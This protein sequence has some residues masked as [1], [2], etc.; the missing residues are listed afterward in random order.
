MSINSSATLTN[1][2]DELAVHVPPEDLQSI[3][4]LNSDQRTAF[5]TIIRAV[6]CNQSTSFFVDG[7]GGTGKT[8]LYRAIIASLRSDGLIAIT[9]ATSGIAATMT[10]KKAF[11]VLDRTLQDITSMETQFG[12]KVRILGEDFRQVLPIMPHGTKAQTI[13]ACIVKSSLWNEIIVIRLKHNMRAQQDPDFAEFLLRVGDGN[14]SFVED[15][16]IRIP[17]SLIIPWHGDESIGELIGFVFP[18]LE[19]NAFNISYMVDRAIITPRN[20][21]IDKLNEVV[22]NSFPGEQHIYYSF[23]KVDNY[24]C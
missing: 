1:I 11:E 5:D 23:D 8:Y 18:R 3:Q 2:Q 17:D 22:L 16:M 13:D 15:D 20:E 24:P 10:Y 19:E 21:D 6:T 4:T 9:T 12:G 14:E 7:T